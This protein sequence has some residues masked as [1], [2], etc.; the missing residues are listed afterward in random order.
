MTNV[1]HLASNLSFLYCS[2]IMPSNI[3]EKSSI[4]AVE[5]T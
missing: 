2:G 1:N 3:I 4:W 5:M